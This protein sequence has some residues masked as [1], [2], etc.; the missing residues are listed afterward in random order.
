MGIGIPVELRIESV[1][2]GYVLKAEYFLPENVSNYLNYIEDPFDVTTRPLNTEFDRKRREMADP[3]ESIEQLMAEPYPAELPIIKN[4]NGFDNVS[5]EQ[6]EI[7]QV[8]AIE[9]EADKLS[10]D[11]YWSKMDAGEVVGS[12]MR[13]KGPQNLG[14]SRWNA[15]KTMAILADL[16]VFCFSKLPNKIS[17]QYFT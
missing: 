16:Y 15:Y 4:Q 3:N 8:P 13:A 2:I 6:Y 5:N 12:P 17:K 10:M 7:Y 14:E 1:T 11:D 9:V